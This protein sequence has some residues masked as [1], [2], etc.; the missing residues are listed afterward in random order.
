[1]KNIKIKEKPFADIENPKKIYNNLDS[2]VVAIIDKLKSKSDDEKF[3]VSRLEVLNLIDVFKQEKLDKAIKD[4]N[5]SQEW[6]RFTVAFYG[7]TNAGKSTIIEA[8]RIYFKEETKAIQ[9]KQFKNI[10]N[11]YQEN[12]I[13]LEEKIKNI[14]ED[15][16]ENKLKIE[17][18]ITD[19]KT[20]KEELEGKIN[21]INSEDL[22][23]KESSFFYKILSF[24]HIVNVQK[25]IEKLISEINK[26]K[27]IYDEEI[28]N[29][30]NFLDEKDKELKK[31]EIGV[32]ELETTTYNSLQNFVDGQ[33]IGDGRSDFTKK[34]TVYNFAYNDQEFAFLDVPGIEGHET[35]VIE[36]ISQAVKKAHAVFYVT[37]SATP[38]Q[39][40]DENKKGTLEK[41]KD[42]LGSQTEVYTV[43]NKRV[44]NPMQLNKALISDDEKESL[45][46]VDEK[47]TEILGE[48]YAGHKSVSA[49]VAF[50]SLAECL[51]AETPI[52]NEQLK[53]L[54]KFSTDD[55]IEKAQFDNLCSF[56]SDKLVTNTKQKIKKSNYNKASNIL[57]ELIGI[58][59]YASKENFEPLYRQ[60]VLE[61]DDALSNLKYS[62]R[63]TKH[64]LEAI[65]EKALRE[66]ENTT[67]KEIYKY[68]DSNVS[69]DSFKNKLE[70]LLE[71]N[72]KKMVDSIPVN[73]ENK[74]TKFQT[75]I[76]DVLENLKRRIDLAI[77]DYQTFDFG[78]F[79]SKFDIKL[80]ID[81]GINGWGVA[82]SLLGAGG[83]VYW[84]VT[85]GNIWNPAGW[86]MATL[87]IVVSAVAVLVSFGKSI[88]KFFSVDYKKSEQRKSADENLENILDDIKPKMMENIEPLVKELTK[89][90]DEIIQDLDNIVLQ[91]KLAYE[92]LDNTHNDLAQLAK[93][94]KKEGEI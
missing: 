77:Q 45:K 21:Q 64:D 49:K 6:H 9:Q 73:I 3:D 47:I 2:N 22:K 81:N 15:I 72:S 17:N 85:A 52:H 27:T 84:A 91:R 4:L 44:T 43:F 23:K 19:F 41:I 79:D 10:F 93:H 30:N 24:L 59:H 53:F 51:L 37:S 46:V 20:K 32:E 56:I 67:R 50:L 63:K 25:E 38:P 33:I 42:H 58:L 74:I 1:M 14:K 13:K 36:E 55:L 54:N 92:Y 88:Y 83:T 39:K 29:L 71:K 62:L 11:E 78:N 48:N 12:K 69:D 28:K 66:F 8:L 86:T 80:N 7:E 26:Q 34:S 60:I 65:I 40:G 16:L 82:G 70:I 68:I 76:T 61:V 57:N 87:G 31:L 94:I 90:I 5:N 18:L 89:L 75:S 35:V